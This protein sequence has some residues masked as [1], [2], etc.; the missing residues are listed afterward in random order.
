MSIT[1]LQNFYHIAGK[2]HE[3]V[4]D[5]RDVKIYAPNNSYLGNFTGY[6]SRPTYK[7]NGHV[8][9]QNE[10]YN[11]WIDGCANA[12]YIPGF[13]IKIINDLI[14]CNPNPQDT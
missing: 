10:G 5:T 9:I 7:S 11:L 2:I 8:C 4:E 1:N 6:T 14:L 12:L 3:V 13:G